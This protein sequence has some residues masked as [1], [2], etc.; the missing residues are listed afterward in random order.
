MRS[1]RYARPEA[2][3]FE[4]V[5]AATRNGKRMDGVPRVLHDCLPPASRPPSR[6][7]PPARHAHA[8]GMRVARQV[9]LRCIV[10]YPEGQQGRRL[11]IVMSAAR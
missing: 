5:C 6:P 4:E 9:S 11:V 1:R 3:F 10:D 2:R 7:S 8:H